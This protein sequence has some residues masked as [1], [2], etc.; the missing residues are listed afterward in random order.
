MKIEINI[1]VNKYFKNYTETVNGLFILS[2][3]ILIEF[4]GFINHSV[5]SDLI[6]NNTA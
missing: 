3:F 2:D 6:R 1:S 4:T 5:V